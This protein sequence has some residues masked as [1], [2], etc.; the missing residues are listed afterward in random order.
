MFG[1]TKKSKK[2]FCISKKIFSNF[3]ARQAQAR[4]AQAKQAQAEK[5]AMSAGQAGDIAAGP[6]PRFTGNIK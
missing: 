6:V 1:F 2:Y 3:E 5:K 4:Q